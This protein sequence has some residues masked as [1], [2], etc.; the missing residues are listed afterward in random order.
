MR[1]SNCLSAAIKSIALL[2]FTTHLQAEPVQIFFDSFDEEDPGQNRLVRDYNFFNKWYVSDGTV[3]LFSQGANNRFCAGNAGKCVDLDGGP[4]SGT[5]TSKE[6][7]FLSAGVYELSF[8]LSGSQA[9]SGSDDTATV[10]VGNLYLEAFTKAAGEP[11]EPITREL[12]VDKPTVANIKFQHTGGDD[13]GLVLDNVSLVR[14]T[15]CSPSIDVVLNGNIFAP[16][17]TLIVTTVVSGP[18]VSCETVSGITVAQT[19][20]LSLPDGSENE[21]VDSFSLLTLANGQEIS[22]EIANFVLDQGLPSGQYVVGASFLDP[23][24]GLVI[25]RDIEVLTFNL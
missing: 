24:S 5:L 15:N 11:F 23:V 17:E 13:I 21:L 2:A 7:L 19:G 20:W 25:A 3:D 10:S 14:N 1:L 16:G 18:D 22:T 6:K 4:S 8:N 9:S 12:I